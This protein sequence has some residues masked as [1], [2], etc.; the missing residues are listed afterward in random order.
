MR[1]A[2]TRCAR[3]AKSRCPKPKD[4]VLAV[5]LVLISIRLWRLARNAMAKEKSI[6]NEK[7]EI[8]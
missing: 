4:V 5:A 1:P 2:I 8:Q 3:M 7:P 6:S